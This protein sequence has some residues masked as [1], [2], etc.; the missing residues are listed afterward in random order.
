MAKV[1]GEQLA[2]FP[3]IEFFFLTSDSEVRGSLTCSNW[4]NVEQSTELDS[5]SDNH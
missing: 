3:F 2:N 1:L 5:H 4:L